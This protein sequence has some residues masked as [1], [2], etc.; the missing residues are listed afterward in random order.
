MDYQIERRSDAVA[1]ANGRIPALRYF[2]AGMTCAAGSAV[3]VEGL[4]LARDPGFA[5]G[6]IGAG[7]AIALGALGLI[8]GASWLFRIRRPHL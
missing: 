3:I 5:I 6:G 4:W 2:N 8:A 1:P 7:V